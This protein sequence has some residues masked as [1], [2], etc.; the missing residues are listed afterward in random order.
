MHIIFVYYI[1]SLKCIPNKELVRNHPINT[2]RHLIHK[3]V[4]K[5]RNSGSNRC[6]QQWSRILTAILFSTGLGHLSDHQLGVRNWGFTL[7]AAFFRRLFGAHPSLNRGVHHVSST[8]PK[9]RLCVFCL[10]N[11]SF[12]R[13][14]LLLKGDLLHMLLPHHMDRWHRSMGPGRGR[15]PTNGTRTP[16]SPQVMSH[17]ELLRKL[18]QKP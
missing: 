3:T 6:N 8:Y 4:T 18:N 7:Y 2:G 9:F 11:V 16:W 17:P 14:C 1:L 12:K 13:E 15:S 10:F 5:R